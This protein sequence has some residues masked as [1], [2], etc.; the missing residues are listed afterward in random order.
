MDE[1]TT[2]LTIAPV[3]SRTPSFICLSTYSR[4][5]CAWSFFSAT[6]ACLSAF[7]ASA[8]VGFSSRTES[9]FSARVPMAALV[10]VTHSSL[11]R[12]FCRLRVPTASWDGTWLLTWPVNRSNTCWS[13][14]RDKEATHLVLEE[15]S[16]RFGGGG[17]KNPMSTNFEEKGVC[18]IAYSSES[19]FLSRGKCCRM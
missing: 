10:E 1:G 2:S 4:C 7:M 13:A 19:F 14:G 12:C 5:C 11:C 6:V 9:T 18:L 8:R 3:P 17:G 16:G 15:K